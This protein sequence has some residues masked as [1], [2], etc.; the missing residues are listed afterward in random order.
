MPMLLRRARLRPRHGLALVALV[1]PCA[2]WALKVPA[3]IP[4]WDRVADP[5][6]TGLALAG[7][8]AALAFAF[9]D[10]RGRRRDRT[11]VLPIVGA[12]GLLLAALALAAVGQLEILTPV[13]ARTIRVPA[14]GTTIYVYD[15][16]FL[17]PIVDVRVR[18]GAWPVS[19]FLTG[20]GPCKPEDVTLDPDGHTLHVCRNTC[21][22]RTRTCDEPGRF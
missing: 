19:D 8:L 7:P 2:A 13:Y 10:L 17:D 12:I 22:L 5:L 14:A 11:L 4:S 9:F 16:S 3:W 1:A 20:N 21:E 18:R 15:A 6:A